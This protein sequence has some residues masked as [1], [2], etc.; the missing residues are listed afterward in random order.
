MC[1]RDRSDL[2]HLETPTHII[3]TRND[4]FF[5]RRCVPADDNCMSATVTFELVQRAGH[6][7]FI[8]GNIPFAG[9]DWLSD[10]IT[11]LICQ[12]SDYR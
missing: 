10:R 6:V 7:A 5:S 12:Q 1:I 11:E 3:F 4:P 2:R 9:H 8:S